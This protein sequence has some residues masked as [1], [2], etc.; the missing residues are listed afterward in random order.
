MSAPN[1]AGSPPP[2]PAV[3]GGL[4]AHL[5]HCIDDGRPV[6]AGVLARDF[7]LGSAAVGDRLGRLERRGLI[8]RQGRLIVVIGVGRTVTPHPGAF[9]RVL[10]ACEDL[11][12]R[13]R[14]FMVAELAAVLGLSEPRLVATCAALRGQA[15][16]AFPR[17]RVVLPDGR[18]LARGPIDWGLIGA[19]RAGDGLPVPPAP[20]GRAGLCFEGTDVDARAVL[21]ACPDEGRRG[22]AT[23]CRGGFSG[24]TAG[25]CAAHA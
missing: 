1:I 6:D 25:A 3:G 17:G 7:G 9:E 8:Q 2:D 5:I 24:S 16:L 13:R 19:N 22:T 15:V 20:P 21:E 14:P 10:Y 4:L 11:A 12:D 23:P 18:V